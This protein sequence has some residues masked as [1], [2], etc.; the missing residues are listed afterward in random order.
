M[1][2]GHPCEE[3]SYKKLMSPTLFAHTWVGS[4]GS[5]F[6]SHLSHAETT[7]LCET[8][9]YTMVPALQGKRWIL[10]K[11]KWPDLHS[12]TKEE[13]ALLGMKVSP[14]GG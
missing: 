1:T 12:Y 3:L 10:R 14:R 7:V 4:G 13:L 5:T 8:T 9:I 11:I 2:E 6:Q